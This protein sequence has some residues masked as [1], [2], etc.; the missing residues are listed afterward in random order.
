MTQRI[1]IDMDGVL[2]DFDQGIADY[3][4]VD[5]DD[6]DLHWDWF[7]CKGEKGG[8]DPKGPLTELES[9]AH[10]RLFP[11][12]NRLWKAIRANHLF[13]KLP[14]MDDTVV[15][16]MA[17]LNA[18]P[19]TVTVIMTSAHPWARADKLWALESRGLHARDIVFTH[20]NDKHLYPFD[21]IIDDKPS[22]L[23]ACYALGE[24]FFARKPDGWP[25][26]VRRN[27]SW[28]QEAKCDYDVDSFGEFAD[29]VE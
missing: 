5:K 19:D 11:S 7:L 6:H 22:T 14:L 25:S 3:L 21:W 4:R 20:Y 26:V 9:C 1:A 28:N 10:C 17:R 15:E 13:A 29:L 18:I 23:N 8:C 16:G 12:R 24:R 2:F 27:H